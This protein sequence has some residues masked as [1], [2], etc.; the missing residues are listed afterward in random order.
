MLS[1]VLHVNHR[2]RYLCLL[3]VRQ[4]LQKS[5]FFIG[6]R[7]DGS[8]L[9]GCAH[10]FSVRRKHTY[11]VNLEAETQEL[12]HFVFTVQIDSQLVQFLALDRTF[13]HGVAK[14][15]VK[16][17]FIRR[18]GDADIVVGQEARLEDFVLPVGVGCP[19]GI[20]ERV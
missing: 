17:A 19:V 2:V 13:F 4:E 14:S 10:A 18:T 6:Y 5:G 1:S 8:C 7:C 11:T 12:S 15:H 20:V 3:E 16:L 9:D